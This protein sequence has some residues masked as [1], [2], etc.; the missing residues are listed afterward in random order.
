MIVKDD[1]EITYY[2][3]YYFNSRHTMHFRIFDTGELLVRDRKVSSF[4]IAYVRG[5]WYASNNNG[6]AASCKIPNTGIHLFSCAKNEYR[7][8]I[9][10]I[11]VEIA[12]H[13]LALSKDVHNFVL[14]LNG[15]YFRMIVADGSKANGVLIMDAHASSNSCQAL[16]MAI[17]AMIGQY[18]PTAASEIES[19]WYSNS[20]EDQFAK[21]AKTI[22]WEGKNSNSLTA[23]TEE[24][25]PASWSIECGH[26]KTYQPSKKQTIINWE[27][28]YAK[29]QATQSIVSNLAENE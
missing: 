29:Q 20:E 6:Q 27:E 4:Y 1:L 3:E 28:E 24:V 5:E 19:F 23:D 12:T 14:F 7:E 16:V 13:K 25:F 17:C 18:S 9:A 10:D 2:D 21:K 15:T 22:D 11:G 26:V 8:Y